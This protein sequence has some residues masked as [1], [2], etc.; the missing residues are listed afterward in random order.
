MPSLH[1]FLKGGALLGVA[2]TLLTISAPAARAQVACNER[3]YRGDEIVPSFSCT[4]GDK[5]YDGFS[6]A[7]AL[8]SPDAT[9][10]WEQFDTDTYNLSVQGLF[11]PG[12]Y[13]LTYN[14]SILDTEPNKS[15]SQLRTSATSAGITP[16]PV[17]WEKTLA[18][19]PPTVPSPL[20]AIQTSEGG[21]SVQ[22]IFGPDV[23]SAAFTSTLIVTSNSVTQF[24]DTISQRTNNGTSVPGPL[25][26]LGAG[27]AFGFS[28]KLRRRIKVVA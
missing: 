8:A 11:G 9:F 25:P 21:A 10:Q 24:Q 17:V 13:A 14:V 16:P 1:T 5:L 20:I 27:A 2:S 22:G 6:V 28:R 19:V 26:L 3:D 23:R 7:G 18:A 4:I 15:F 12:T